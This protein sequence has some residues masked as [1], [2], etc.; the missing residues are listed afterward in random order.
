MFFNLP[1]ASATGCA[2]FTYRLYESITGGEIDTQLFNIVVD[3]SIPYVRFT[4]PLRDP[5]LI[6]SP[7][8]FTLEAIYGTLGSTLSEPIEVTVLDT[9]FNT[10][11]TPANIV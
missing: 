2:I 6:S 7:F 8:D 11:I 10:K 9:C 5:W 3:V 4:L 1:T